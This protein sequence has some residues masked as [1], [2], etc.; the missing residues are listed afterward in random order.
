M[1]QYQQYQN[2]ERS[3]VRYTTSESDG[4]GGTR[5][6]TRYSYSDREIMHMNINLGNISD[7]IPEGARY[8]FPFQ[9]ELPSN[10]PSTMYNEGVGRAYCQINYKIKAEL[11]SGD[12]SLFGKHKVQVEFNVMSKPLPIQPVPNLIQPITQ[13]VNF[14]CCFNIGKITM[15][16]R[17]AD[18]RIGRGE[19]VIIDFA[20]QNES[21]VNIQRAEVSVKQ[22]VDWKSGSRS[23]GDKKVI[24]HNI[25]KQT[26]RWEKID[27][28]KMKESKVK[29]R[30]P[31]DTYRGEEQR[32]LQLIHA[33]IHDGEN[34]ALLSIP[35]SAIQSYQ[36][37][38]IKVHHRLKIKVF[39]GGSCTDNPTIK[40]PIFIGTPSNY[41]RTQSDAQIESPTIEVLPPPTAPT[42]IVTP[43][44]LGTPTTVSPSAPPSEWA[45][46]V[47]ATPVVI[48]QSTAVVGGNIWEAEEGGGDTNQQSNVIPMAAAEIVPTLES[49]L[50]EIQ[51]SVSAISTIQNRIDDDTWKM[52]VFYTLNPQDYA[53]VIN[54]VPIEFDQPEVA[55]LVG[56]LVN[57][58]NFTHR[59]II[60]ALGAV[61]DWLRTPL[62]TKVL[63]LCTDLNEN[64]DRIKA[65][66]TDWELVC[67]QRDFESAAVSNV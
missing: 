20:C 13:H 5:T 26:S 65:E 49:L 64:G 40:M 34:R 24:A 61:A 57:A 51:Y 29:S 52:K 22:E 45:S 11:L 31:T 63:P 46:A 27:K 67:T 28:A 35:T 17:V 38:L 42:A 44:T 30:A 16:A 48:G 41:N 19:K 59:Y 50:K 1:Y 9:I 23:N 53:K 3:N 56:P 54:S 36:G 6:T 66:L 47:V 62:L 4:N 10:I 2:R 33:A 60:A 37:A 12:K 25:F 18:T 58:C 21:L 7:A 43:L 39:T 55:A 8:R 32:I 14:L 15:G